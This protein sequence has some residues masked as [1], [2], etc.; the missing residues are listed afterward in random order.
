MQRLLAA[1]NLRSGQR[2]ALHSM[3]DQTGNQQD[4]LGMTPLHILTSSS[5][6]NLELYRLI[7]EKYPTNLI[8]EDRWGALPLLYAFWGAAPVEIIQFLLARYQSLYPNHA[9]NWTMMVETMGRTDTPKESIE[10]LLHVRQMHF[11]EQPIDWEYLLDEFVNL[12]NPSD[13]CF[14]STFTERMQFLIMCGLS[15]R[16]EA[17]A[18]KVWRDHIRHLIQT[19]NFKSDE[20]NSGIL[21]GIRDK[22]AHLEDK[23][24]KLKEATTILE[25]ALWKMNIFDTSHQQKSFRR[26]KEMK[27]EGAS[28]RQQC[29]VTCGAD[30]IIGHVLPYLI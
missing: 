24:P 15:L 16:V 4:C 20:N 13:F 18:F 9:F 7:V 2:G 5:V 6:H 23:L 21:N 17:L 22:L 10:N 8:T 27:V 12:A 19:A 14:P 26:Q 30:V 25:L 29:R 11:P 3:M 28:P 1:M